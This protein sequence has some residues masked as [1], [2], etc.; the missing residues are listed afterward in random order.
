ICALIHRSSTDTTSLPFA[1]LA[2]SALIGAAEG[3]KATIGERLRTPDIAGSERRVPVDEA[4]PACDRL[5]G[6]VGAHQYRMGGR[7]RPGIDRRR[8][9]RDVGPIVHGV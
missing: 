3:A 2:R 6:P 7:P 9:A 1:Q 8:Q 5:V 4:R